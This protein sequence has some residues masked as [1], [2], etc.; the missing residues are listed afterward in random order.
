[1]KKG[2]PNPVDEREPQHVFEAVKSLGLQYVVITSVT[3][4]DIADGG[5]SQFVRTIEILHHQ[6]KGVSVEVLIPDFGGSSKALRAVVQVR[7]EVL[8]HN[9]E[10]VHRLYPEVRPGADYSRSLKLL[11]DVKRIDPEI[12]TKSGLMLGLGESKEEIIETMSDLREANCDLLTIGQYLQ[13]T[14]K[15]HPVVAFVLP[16]EFSEYEKIGKKMG[17]A[18]LLLIKAN[19]DNL[20]KE[21]LTEGLQPIFSSAEEMSSLINSILDISKLEDGEMPVS[22]TAVNGLQLIK[23]LCEQFGPQAEGMGVNLSFEPESDAIMTRA[24]KQLLSRILQN[25]ITNAFKHT[26]TGTNVTVSIKSHGS[27]VVFCVADN[28]PGIP[29]EYRDKIFGKFFQIETDT[30]GK[31]YGVGLGLAFCKM[32]VEA[33]DGSIWVES[34]HG[35]GSTFKVS[36]EAIEA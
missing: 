2:S 3:R 29:E 35:K 24:D 15:H 25:L 33:Q 1:M 7:P 13:P 5:A 22:L 19:Q 9:M 17:F 12:V 20:D 21:T 27:N 28:G 6:G 31:K 23:D 18:E 4:D 10:T 11:F 36:L 26:A 30:K 32:A 8:N 16:E 34:E 14:P